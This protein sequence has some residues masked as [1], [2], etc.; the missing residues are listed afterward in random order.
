MSL[1]FI[2][3]LCFLPIVIWAY[4]FSYIDW[5]KL[6]KNR[7]LLWI[8]SWIISVLP[9]I[10]YSKIFE[11]LNFSNL[12]NIFSSFSFYYYILFIGTFFI[13]IF[14]LNLFFSFFTLNKFFEKI[15]ILLKSLL[16]FSIVSI[17]LIT[18]TYFLEYLWI[19]SHFLLPE[20][21]ISF[22]WSNLSSFRLVLFYYLFISIVEEFAKY[23]WFISSSLFSVDNVRKAVLYSIF[24]TLWFVLV[25]NILYLYALIFSNSSYSEVIKIYFFR[26]IFSLMVHILCS[27][28]LIYN[29]S[30][31]Y[32]KYK[33]FFYFNFLK[34]FFMWFIF[35][36]FSHSIFDILMSYGWSFMIVIYFIISYFYLTA[37]FYKE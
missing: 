9:I 28:L 8:F 22:S 21:N 7:F 20:S 27:S 12:T 16:L 23:M 26:F 15:I 5:N 4:I 6:N 24:V 14:L 33:K 19:F 25:E 35:S 29:F 34:L 13:S 30:R 32:F 10:F 3:F 1:I 31:A 37:I 17:I 36:I 18:I 11:F 2:I